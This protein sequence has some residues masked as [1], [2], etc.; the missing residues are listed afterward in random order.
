MFG[1]SRGDLLDNVIGLMTMS[2][3]TEMAHQDKE[4]SCDA[5]TLV[6]FADV[7]LDAV[8]PRAHDKPPAARSPLRAR[9]DV[10]VWNLF[11]PLDKS[12]VVS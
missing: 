6:R 2:T 1:C 11:Y 12:D 7:W 3:V 10:G 9:L 8:Y 4:W 5:S